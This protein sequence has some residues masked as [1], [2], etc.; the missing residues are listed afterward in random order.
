MGRRHLASGTFPPQAP[1]PHHRRDEPGVDKSV[2][3]AQGRPQTLQA[4]GMRPANRPESL[5]RPL[6]PVVTATV[7]IRSVQDGKMPSISTRNTCTSQCP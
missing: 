4:G 3:H 6:P 2:A 5:R 1:P 7:L